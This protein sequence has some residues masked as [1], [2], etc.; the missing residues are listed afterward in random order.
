MIIFHTCTYI[1][2]VL[3]VVRDT[4]FIK[5]LVVPFFVGRHRMRT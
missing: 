2:V 3:I 1:P 5:T 4:V